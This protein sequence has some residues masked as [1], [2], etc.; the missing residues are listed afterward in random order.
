MTDS[1]LSNEAKIRE[2]WKAENGV[3]PT[4]TEFIKIQKNIENFSNELFKNKEWVD[5]YLAGNWR[6]SKDGIKG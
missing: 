1:V 5:D 4:P 2:H 6:Q 3:E